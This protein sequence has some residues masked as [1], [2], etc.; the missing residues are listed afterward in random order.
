MIY[1][2][3]HLYVYITTMAK[4]ENIEFGREKKWERKEKGLGKV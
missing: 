2:Y 1:I 4:E 3:I